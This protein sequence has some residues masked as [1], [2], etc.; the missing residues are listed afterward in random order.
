MGQPPTL[1]K[2]L[3]AL[4]RQPKF[5]ASFFKLRKNMGANNAI[6]NNLQL[7][8]ININCYLLK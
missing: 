5:C 3:N 4:R 6:A 7:K 1:Q 8:S 2:S